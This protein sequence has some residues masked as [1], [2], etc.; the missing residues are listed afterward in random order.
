MLHVLDNV[1]RGASFE[2]LLPNQCPKHKDSEPFAKPNSSVLLKLKCIFLSV[3]V[4][5][6]TGVNL[7]F[8]PLFSL[9]SKGTFI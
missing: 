6:V 2:S 3:S 7:K 1:R 4:I 9:M 8:S 5:F